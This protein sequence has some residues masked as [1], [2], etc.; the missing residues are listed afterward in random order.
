MK[1]TKLNLALVTGAVAMIISAAFVSPVFG[2]NTSAEQG[3]VADANQCS[4]PLELYN[5]EV[6]ANTMADPAKFIQFM[7]A[8]S[9][10]ETAQKMMACSADA[11]QWTIMM[12]NMANPNLMMNA[13]VPFMNP[14]TYMNWAAASMNPMTYQ[15]AMTPFMNPNYYMQWMTAFMNPEFYR[16]MAEM[17]DMNEY[18]NMF[19]S[20]YKLPVVADAS[21]AQ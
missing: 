7:T 21:A 18:T 13:M 9:Q 15:Q 3:T 16:P 5:P 2:E 8:M 6:M 19:E 10:P 14:Q 1:F 12:T 20:M 4:L 11:G 17:M